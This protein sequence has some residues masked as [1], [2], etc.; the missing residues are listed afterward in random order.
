[1]S[2]VGMAILVEDK[3]SPPHDDDAC[4]VATDD[5]V[6]LSSKAVSA[7]QKRINRYENACAQLSLIKNPEKA[8]N[9]VTAGTLLGID[10]DGGRFL[11]PSASGVVSLW[12]AVSGANSIPA[13]FIRMVQ[14][15]EPTY[16]GGLG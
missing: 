11:G 5:V 16:L 6:L 9:G 2:G 1:M 12:C 14:S 15:A 7:G 3:E 13:R 4:L 8:L 10:L